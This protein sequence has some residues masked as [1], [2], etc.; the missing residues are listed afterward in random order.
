MA[1]MA[2]V[3]APAPHPA[4]GT[5]PAKNK[6]PLWSYIAVF[7]LFLVQVL[8]LFFA[9]N[10]EQIAEQWQ[11]PLWVRRVARTTGSFFD[12]RFAYLPRPTEA[13][14]VALISISQESE[15]TLPD[16]CAVRSFIAG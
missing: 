3:P 4:S 5:P 16:A 1:G 9:E 14:Y 15:G 12:S 2:T 11:S 6:R 13:H 7:I 8:M 10:G